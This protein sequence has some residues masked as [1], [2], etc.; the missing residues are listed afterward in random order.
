[1][2]KSLYVLSNLRTHTSVREMNL[3]I[4]CS[5]KYTVSFKKFMVYFCKLNYLCSKCFNTILL[6]LYPYIHKTKQ[7]WNRKEHNGYLLA[8]NKVCPKRNAGF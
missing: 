7:S 4:F 5:L 2:T 1:M 6:P 8:T 3:P